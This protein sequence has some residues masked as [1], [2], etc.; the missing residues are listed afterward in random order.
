MTALQR[1]APRPSPGPPSHIQLFPNIEDTFRT[2][3]TY[4][5]AGRHTLRSM[6][7]CSQLFTNRDRTLM[8]RSF[9][10]KSPLRDM[11]QTPCQHTHVIHIMHTIVLTMQQPVPVTSASLS[12]PA[13]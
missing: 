6:S 11:G 7:G 8:K 5:R 10:A 12:I 1:K 4:S 13:I 9:I 3:V 2:A